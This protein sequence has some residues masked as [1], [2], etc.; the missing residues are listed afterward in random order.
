L[1]TAGCQALWTYAKTC[2]PG[3]SWN[4]LRTIA[5]DGAPDEGLVLAKQHPVVRD[6]QLAGLVERHGQ[7][8]TGADELA[9]SVDLVADEDTAH[10]IPGAA[11]RCGDVTTT[12]EIA[13]VRGR[14]CGREISGC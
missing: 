14:S 11:C 12:V 2:C 7:L 3:S 9:L 1:T 6:A 10:P 8:N 4:P 5:A 13:T